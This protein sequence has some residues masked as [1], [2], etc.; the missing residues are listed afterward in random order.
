MSKK[1]LVLI[2]SYITKIL[3][4]RMQDVSG[5]FNIIRMNA[6]YTVYEK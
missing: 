4:S 3:G 1:E 5:C 6:R 2:N